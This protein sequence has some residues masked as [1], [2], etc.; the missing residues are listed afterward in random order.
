MLADADVSDA[1]GPK[2]VVLGVCIERAAKREYITQGRGVDAKQ[3]LQ[4]WRGGRPQAG[5]PA[6]GADRTLQIPP[7]KRSQTSQAQLPAHAA[8]LL[9]VP[10]VRY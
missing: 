8:R 1:S 7:Q 9:R 10:A 3:P 6:G 2:C 4:R 5:S